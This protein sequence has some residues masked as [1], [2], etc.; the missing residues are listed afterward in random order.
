MQESG[1]PGLEPYLC[2]LWRA[3]MKAMADYHEA[4]D[5]VRRF[6]LTGE[7]GRR[8]VSKALNRK[9]QPEASCP[10]FRPGVGEAANRCRY[11]FLETCLL[12]FPECQERCDDFLPQGDQTG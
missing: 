3:R 11:F 8:M 6:G 1:K 10:D 12:T 9:P 5:R 2:V 7:E 4:A